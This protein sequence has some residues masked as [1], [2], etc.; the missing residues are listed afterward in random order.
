MVTSGYRMHQTFYTLFI[1]AAGQSVLADK[2]FILVLVYLFIFFYRMKLGRDDPGKCSA[3][4]F[5][6]V[7]GS[8]F[9]SYFLPIDPV[10]TNEEEVFSYRIGEEKYQSFL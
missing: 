4:P 7:F 9:L 10:F 6:N 3:I 5:R 2:V 8:S 1:A